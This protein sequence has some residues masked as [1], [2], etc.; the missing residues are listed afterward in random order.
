MKKENEIDGNKAYR[1]AVLQYFGNIDPR[2]FEQVAEVYEQK[3]KD[4]DSLILDEGLEAYPEHF[5]WVLV[6]SYKKLKMD[7]ERQIRPWLFENAE[8]LNEL[9]LVDVY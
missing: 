3:I 4:L 1:Y 6:K 8:V 9:D 7:I 2:E 5:L